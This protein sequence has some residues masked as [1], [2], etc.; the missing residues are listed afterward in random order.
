MRLVIEEPKEKRQFSRF[1]FRQPVLI[2]RGEWEAEEGSLSGDVSE[3][4][5]RLNVNELIPVG[6]TLSLEVSLPNESKM[7][8]LNGRVA[9]VCFLPY[10]ERYQM[11]IQFDPRYNPSKSEILRTVNPQLQNI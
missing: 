9:W 5:I 6:S 4:G 8:S 10:S 2:N 3:G 11:G 1:P 7:A